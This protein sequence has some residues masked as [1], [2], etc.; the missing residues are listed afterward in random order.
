MKFTVTSPKI[1]ILEGFFITM[2]I[3]LTL[4]FPNDFSVHIAQR[5]TFIPNFVKIG[6]VESEIQRYLH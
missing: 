2:A 5:P 3:D 4:G 1:A 6:P